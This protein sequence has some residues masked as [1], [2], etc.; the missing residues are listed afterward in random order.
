M[1]QC[2]LLQRCNETGTA[3][4][5]V[6][7]GLGRLSSCS[8]AQYQFAALTALTQDWKVDVGGFPVWTCVSMLCMSVHVLLCM[9]MHV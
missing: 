1:M 6:C 7:Y 8:S 5:V 3:F 9:L 2:E 4:D